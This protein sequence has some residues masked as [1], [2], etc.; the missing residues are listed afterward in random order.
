MPD[1]FIL[2]EL[3]FSGHQEKFVSSL[4]KCIASIPVIDVLSLSEALKDFKIHNV[5]TLAENAILYPL[6]PEFES[7]LC[8]MNQQLVSKCPS[9]YLSTH[10]LIQK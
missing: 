7:V 10:I 8:K 2:T 3:D 9:L 1:I 5:E 4:G 6:S